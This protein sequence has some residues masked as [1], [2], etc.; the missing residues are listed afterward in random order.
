[1]NILRESNEK[2]VTG[3]LTASLSAWPITMAEELLKRTQVLVVRSRRWPGGQAQREALKRKL[4][5]GH[6]IGDL[7]LLFPTTLKS[8]ARGE[9]RGRWKCPK[10][11]LGLRLRRGVCQ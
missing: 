6:D 1:M 5:I 3:K 7:G 9:I 8:N 11:D 2:M 10:W 4:L